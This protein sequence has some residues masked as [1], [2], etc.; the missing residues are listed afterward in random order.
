[1]E[2]DELA[3]IDRAI[4]MATGQAA[5]TMRKAVN[6]APALARDRI[7][8]RRVGARRRRLV[9]LGPRPDRSAESAGLSIAVLPFRNLSG[10]ADQDF[11]SE[12]LTEEI[13]AALAR[14]PALNVVA[15]TSSNAAK[16]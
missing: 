11:L 2:R 15:A 10:D 7:R 4:A 3:A 8:S 1:M 5:P 9:R 13:R 14:N 12:G 16:S 6:F